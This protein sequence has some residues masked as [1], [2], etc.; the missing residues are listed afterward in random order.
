MTTEWESQE[1]PLP[2]ETALSHHLGISTFELPDD[3]WSRRSL[4]PESL[5]STLS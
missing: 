5:A 4:G 3:A 2:Q 1:P